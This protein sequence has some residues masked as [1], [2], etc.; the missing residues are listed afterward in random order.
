MKP[1]IPTGLP[2]K[3]EN[4]LTKARLVSFKQLYEFNNLCLNKSFLRKRTRAAEEDILDLQKRV[5]K[6]EGWRPDIEKRM[7]EQFEEATERFESNDKRH[8]NFKKEME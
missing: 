8:M 4:T 5:K 6:L 1:K 3:K 7:A 2:N